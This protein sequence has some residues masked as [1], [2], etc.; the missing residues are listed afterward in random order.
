MSDYAE[1]LSSLAEKKQKLLEEETRLVEK[2]IKEI[3]QLAEKFGMLTVSDSV[4]VGLF[5]EASD[6]IKQNSAKLKSW[7]QAGAQSLKPK[8]NIKEAEASTV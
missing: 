2:R 3:G 4:I 5:T 6:A 8:R 1:K 7:E